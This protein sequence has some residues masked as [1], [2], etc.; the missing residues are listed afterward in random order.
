MKRTITMLAMSAM[1]VL[2]FAPAALAQGSA[3]PA[4]DPMPGFNQPDYLNPAF[5]N[6]DVPGGG[7][8]APASPNATTN[9]VATASP[10]ATAS[11]G[12]TADPSA[13]ASASTSATSSAS[14][15]ASAGSLPDT[16]GVPLPGSRRRGL[17][18]AASLGRLGSEAHQGPQHLFLGGCCT[19]RVGNMS[20]SRTG[21][22]RKDPGPSL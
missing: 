6:P 4:L 14:P 5:D 20:P 19:S 11:P 15:S 16:G 9:P 3:P 1:A 18:G 21:V 13:S 22:L 10:S 7:A 8:T 12:V 17:P 2:L